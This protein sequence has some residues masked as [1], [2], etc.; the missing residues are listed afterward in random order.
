M[1]FSVLTTR[2]FERKLRKLAKKYLSLVDDLDAL[3]KKLE[4]NPTLGI[5]LGKDCYKISMAIT[6]KGQGKSGGARIIT[7][8]RI[9]KNTVYM[10]NIYDKLEQETIADREMQ[11]NI[12]YEKV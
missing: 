11:N 3:G 10:L 8:V 1:S 2:P 4:D 6:S 5:P 12:K 7:C 9:V